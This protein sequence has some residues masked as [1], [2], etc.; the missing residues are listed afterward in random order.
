MMLCHHSARRGHKE[1]I[2]Q[3]E[4]AENHLRASGL[5]YTIIRPGGFQQWTI[6]RQGKTNRRSFSF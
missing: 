5:S 3:K 1:V 2:S 6:L 4:K